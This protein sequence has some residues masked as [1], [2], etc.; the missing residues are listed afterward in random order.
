MAQIDA[1]ENKTPLFSS[2][3][4]CAIC[5]S[6]L[7]NSSTFAENHLTARARARR[8]AKERSRPAMGSVLRLA[9]RR[10]IDL[11]VNDVGS[12]AGVSSV[13]ARGVEM[14]AAGTARIT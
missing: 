3:L 6:N 4:V 14:V 10:K 7:F 11:T 2:A 1:D 9:S 8:R 13:Q 12:R 5:G